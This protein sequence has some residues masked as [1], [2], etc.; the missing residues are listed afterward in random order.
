MKKIKILFFAL[1]ILNNCEENSKTAEEYFK[2]G[3]KNSNSGNYSAAIINY[4]KALAI[5]STYAKAYYNIAIIKAV[6]LE[7]SSGACENARK[8][9]KF[10]FTEINEYK[11]TLK[12]NDLIDEVCN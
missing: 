12:V 3:M 11:S 5:D 6:M 10:G 2:I 4:Q 9:K 8:A 7:D 1:L